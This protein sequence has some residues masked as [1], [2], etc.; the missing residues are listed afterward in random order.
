MAKS[1]VVS[2]ARPQPV[3][4]KGGDLAQLARS[5]QRGLQA[6]N[7][8][9]ATV[10]IYTISVSQLANFLEARGM[11][12]VVA[13]L[14]RE[15]I[16]MWLSDVL[17]RR[18]A[19]TAET[20]YRGAKS[21][22]DWL[23]EEGELKVS[24]MA[25]VKRPQIAEV[26]PPMLTDDEMRRLLAA[27]DGK[28]FMER[29]DTAI[30][31]LFLDTGLRRSELAYLRLDDVDLDHSVVSVV[32]KFRRPRVVPFGRK[33]AQALDRYLRVR[34]THRHSA[35][36]AFWLGPQGPL[37]DSAVDLMV[38]RRARQAGLPPTHAHLFRHG[39]AHAWLA[40]GGQEQD[41]MQLAGWK[42]RTMLGRYGAS[43][44]AER[45]REAYRRLSPGDRL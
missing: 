15:H 23:V 13:N 26:P 29:R 25:H 17:E 30:I 36:E 24:P 6:A 40:Q 21:F 9:P 16:E 43:A 1:A 44:A 35:E 34:A 42:S 31:R 7:R 45:A 37:G 12:L 33:T 11:P 18:S 14:T 39:F 2:R 22:F 10:R 4:V 19:G 20:R 3:T 41:L 32:G 27:C 8:S 5:F 28:E 38:R